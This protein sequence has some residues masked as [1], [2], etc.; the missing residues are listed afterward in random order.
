MKLKLTSLLLATVFSPCGLAVAQEQGVISA[1]KKA[2]DE[3]TA[4]DRAVVQA[5]N[6]LQAARDGLDT[7]RFN[8]PAYNARI[9]GQQ[10][11]A[12]KEKYEKAGPNEKED[13]LEV[14]ELAQELAEQR[15]TELQ[16]AEKVLPDRE[17]AARAAEEK[18][19][20][21]LA[22][23]EQRAAEIKALVRAAEAAAAEKLND[24]KRATERAA[25]A[26]ANAQ[27]RAAANTQIQKNL[28]D[29]VAADKALGQAATAVKQA[30]D[31]D[32]PQKLA[33]A[34]KATKAYAIALVAAAP[35]LP[36]LKPDAANAVALKASLAVV[37][38]DKAAQKATTALQQAQQEL[39]NRINAVKQA[40][41]RVKAAQDGVEK[42]AAKIRARKDLGREQEAAKRAE[43]AKVDAEK[44][45]SPKMADAEKAQKESAA[46]L[47]AAVKALVQPPAETEATLATEKAAI[48]K[49]MADREADIKKENESLTREAAEA[50]AAADKAQAAATAADRLAAERTTARETLSRILRQRFYRE[51]NTAQNELRRL[52]TAIAA[53]NRDLQPRT[54]AFNRATAELKQAQDNAAKAQKEAAAQATALASAASAKSAADKAAQEKA[55][56]KDAAEKNAREAQEASNA[57][58]E[59]LK[60]AAD[61][62]KQPA[63]KQA[64]EKQTA[65]KTAAQKA[66]ETEQA[67]NAARAALEKTVAALKAAE[68]R[69]A[70]TAQAAK[71][72]DQK[73]TAARAALERATAEKNAA[74][75]KVNQQRQALDLAPSK[76]AVAKASAYGGLK[77]L[78]DSAWD[79]AK[80]RHL[81]VR[82]GFGGT[83]DEVAKLQ[84]M[85]LHRAVGYFV[86]FKNLPAPEIAF[87]AH[88]KERPENYESVLSGDEQRRLQQ[89]RVAKDREQI[90]NMRV[91]WLRR[92]IESPRPL[93]EKL[94]LFWHG[95]IPAQYSDVGDSYYMYLQ[96][97]LF[98]ANAAGNFSTLLHGIAHDAAMLKYLN[99]DTNVKGRANENLAREIMELFSMGRDQGYSEIDIRQGARALTGYTY[100]AQTGQFR[101]ISD[102]H[103]TDPKTIFGKAGNWCGDDFVRLILETPYPAKFVARQMFAFFAHDEPS[104]D[105]I[106][107]LANVLRLNNYELA[108]M[109]ENLFLSEEFYSARAMTTQIKGPVQLVVG[110]H[111]DLGLK[112]ADYGYLTA[113]LREM[114]QDLFEPPSVFGWQ[115]GRAWIS[116]SRAFARYNALAEI[117]ANR[118]RAGRTGVDVVGTV[119]AGKTFQN[120]GEVVDYLLKCAWNVPVSENKRQALIEFLKPLPQPGQWMTNPGPVNARLTQLLVMLMCSPEYQLS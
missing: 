87:V 18:Y 47:Q 52:E 26:K 101:F 110:L 61:A 31:Q 72:A 49:A 116:T 69:A 108:P 113:A 90:Q 36:A 88:P 28:A 57:A 25:F 65:A 16:A 59:A 118:P 76:I 5:R 7:E 22:A 80:A 37:E 46:A 119:L 115:S 100:D 120:H 23:A 114:G 9:T 77:P 92:M 70:D 74:E 68:K 6:A 63:E 109:L 99:N 73:V 35:H 41:G 19:A 24:S 32:R 83:P 53:A 55:A 42:R 78:A 97:E 8:S 14:Y 3:L 94:T 17:A 33:E 1:V 12:A 48:V 64:K 104:I 10:A 84:A 11:Q 89:Q 91:W 98:R 103:D 79:Y 81:L 45:V 75:G 2:T 60:K 67:A 95:Q 102:R 4:A 106:E 66:K 85:G 21:A 43:T 111:R 93:E 13:A 38:A 107:A 20:T 44:A 58:Q 30:S 40:E 86:H 51:V 82:A 15:K 54:A 71:D 105:T 62:E 117:V 29:L 34:E 39:Q 50:Q 56:A 112:N 96:N 27:Q